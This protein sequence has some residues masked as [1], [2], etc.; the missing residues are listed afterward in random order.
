MY[1]LEMICLRRLLRNAL[2]AVNTGRQV[3]R[4]IIQGMK[5]NL[6]TLST[7]RQ[8]NMPKEVMQSSSLRGFK[9][10]IFTQLDKALSNLV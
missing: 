3:E 10:W 7:A 5:R 9:V 8:R 2:T 6:F 4:E 1:S